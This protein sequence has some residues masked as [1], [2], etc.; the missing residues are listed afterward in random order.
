MIL[1]DT[2][3]M[4][5]LSPQALAS[6][7]TGGGVPNRHVAETPIHPHGE[8]SNVRRA[9][10]PFSACRKLCRCNI[11]RAIKACRGGAQDPR[12][13]RL[14][15]MGFA[16]TLNDH[17]G[18]QR[19]GGEGGEGGGS[20]KAGSNHRI[21]EIAYRRALLWRRYNDSATVAWGLP[22][23]SRA[24]D[25]INAFTSQRVVHQKKNRIVVM[26]NTRGAEELSGT[27]D[28]LDFDEGHMA[29]EGTFREPI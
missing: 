6:G 26:S 14:D 3:T 28:S 9:A 17:S 13:Q 5:G 22:R 27:G 10:Q 16:W 21:N 19:E 25:L 29:E 4:S 7:C 1:E 2:R 20:V 23:Q 18:E 12:I 8:G 11:A 24:F 15:H